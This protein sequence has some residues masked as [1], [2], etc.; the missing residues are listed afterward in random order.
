MKKALIPLAS[1]FEEIEAISIIDILRRG[2]IEVVTASAADSRLV[3]G[4][5]GI[6]I[7]ADTLLDSC[8]EDEFDIIILPGG[9]KGTENL[10][11]N[12]A[13]HARLKRQKES[14]GFIGAICAAPLVL[15]KAE[16]L[17]GEAVTCYPTCA[18]DMK[19][20]VARAPVVVDGQIITGQAPGSAMLFAL[21][22]LEQLMTSVHARGI[23]A[24]LVTDVY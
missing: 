1:G 10:L 3:K 5:H 9:G 4:A 15:K 19:Y 20:P 16:V 23:A 2:E 7:E 21:V 18:K 14:G 22:V 6:D 8:L 13:L 24:G 17:G 11:E 12:E